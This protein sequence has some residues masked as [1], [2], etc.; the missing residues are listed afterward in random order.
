MVEY[1]RFFWQ[2]GW[3]DRALAWKAVA[4]ILVTFPAAMSAFIGITRTEL[5]FPWWQ[6][7]AF[8]LLAIVAAIMIGVIKRA[9]E[10]ERVVAPKMEIA[11][12][13]RVRTGLYGPESE[14]YS[15]FLRNTGAATLH[16]VCLRAL[17]SPF[18][19]AIIAE[20][21]NPAPVRKRAPVLLSGPTTVDPDVTETIELFGLGY[22]S[23]ITNSEAILNNVQT[24][25]LEAHAKDTRAVRRT[26]Q[27][28]PN[29]RPMLKMLD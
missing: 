10:L 11:L 5:G 1:L 24:F 2:A 16:E 12:N 14:F 17:D 23:N 8:A 13:T 7:A 19:V 22:N 3:R 29:A 27:F 6:W 4:L 21:K 26:F 20:A 18:T 9:V 25:V 28:D 15:I